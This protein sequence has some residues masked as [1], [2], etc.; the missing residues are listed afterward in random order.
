MQSFMAQVAGKEGGQFA[1]LHKVV[2][3]MLGTGQSPPRCEEAPSEE[4]ARAHETKAWMES[5]ARCLAAENAMQKHDKHHIV[6]T[7]R[8]DTATQSVKSIEDEIEQNTASL[9][10]ARAE[11]ATAHAER[12]S[13]T[14]PATFA[15]QRPTQT[16]SSDQRTDSRWDVVEEFTS[17]ASRYVNK[18]TNAGAQSQNEPATAAGLPSAGEENGADEMQIDPDIAEEELQRAQKRVEA[19]TS[20]L[21]KK[22]RTHADQEEQQRLLLLQRDQDDAEPAEKEKQAAEDADK[23][24]ERVQRQVLEKAES[25][26]AAASAAK[27]GGEGGTP[28]GV[29]STTPAEVARKKRE[30]EAR[31]AAEAESMAP[32]QAANI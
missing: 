24:V 13:L 16:A 9:K 2:S 32:G 21:A 11:H 18:K 17:A 8:L 27:A 19:C 3:G 26:A 12:D 25:D 10:A 20:A 1:A 7:R 28:P 29:G 15:N 23:E 4:Q 22:R 30:R 31:E 14:I 6:L 5:R